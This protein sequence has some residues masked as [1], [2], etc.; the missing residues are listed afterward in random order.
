MNI[1]VYEEIGFPNAEQMFLKAKLVSRI[2]DIITDTG[3]T[4][5]KVA[6]IAGLTQPQVSN[7]LRGRFED[8]GP[9]AK[10]GI[11]QVAFCC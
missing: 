1:N 11:R 2:S 8:I 5:S 10:S 6:E 9:V 3:L 7:I 4:Q